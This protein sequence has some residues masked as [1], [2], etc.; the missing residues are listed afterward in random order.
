MLASTVASSLKI[1]ILGTG[2]IGSIFAY[3]FARVG[4]HDVTMI[5]RPGSVR[6]QQL[7][8][9]DGIIDVNGERARVRVTDMLDEETPHD[10]LIVTLLDHQMDAVLPSLKR[11]AARCNQFM[12]NTFRP[13]NCA[14]LSASSAANSAC[15]SFEGSSEDH[16]ERAAL[17]RAL[18]RRRDPSSART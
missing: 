5:A 8:R 10:L 6:L 9:D 3:Q 1:A 13:S 16:H 15:R 14:T 2:K 7:Q 4:Y 11:S 18:Q 12:F 17:G